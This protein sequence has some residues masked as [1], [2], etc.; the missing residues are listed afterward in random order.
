MV[1]GMLTSFIKTLTHAH[2]TS[3]KQAFQPLVSATVWLTL[4]LIV[5]GAATRVYDAGMSCPDW[6]QCYGVWVPFPEARVP[7]G[8]V[9]AGQH[10][11]WWQVLL[12]WGHRGLAAIVGFGLLGLLALA[13]AR[14]QREWGPLATAVLLL[15]VQ[16]KLGAVTVWLSNIHWTVALHLGNAM[17]FLA[18]LAWLRREVASGGQR[19][20]PSVPPIMPALIVGFAALVWVTMIIGAL[21]SS[22]HSGGVC[23]GLMS[24]D[25]Q[26]LPDDWQQLLHMKHRFLA[27][28]LIVFSIGLLVAAKRLAPSLRPL[29][30]HLH[31]VLWGQAL[32]GILTLYSFANYPD[33]YYPLSILHLTWGTVLWLGAMGG[34]LSLRY[35]AAGRFHAAKA[36]KA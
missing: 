6:P 33:W 12:E 29:A 3:A 15:A 10:Y 5:V 28:M 1:R 20:P 19:T 23:G 14:P 36:H 8:Y 32:L 25:G 17:L 16:I 24:C 26:W 35:G 11:V 27:A 13:P 4:L 7:G 21:V 2:R 18:A 30:L 34:V 9:V 31:L 22:S